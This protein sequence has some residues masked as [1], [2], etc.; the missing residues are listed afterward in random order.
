MARRNHSDITDHMVLTAIANLVDV[1]RSQEWHPDAP[2]S[3]IIENLIHTMGDLDPVDITDPA[4]LIV[5]A[6]PGRTLS[7]IRPN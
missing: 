5:L 6:N 3:F 4:V 1:H 7:L 2:I